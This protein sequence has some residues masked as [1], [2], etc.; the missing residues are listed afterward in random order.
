MMETF[1]KMVEHGFPFWVKGRD[2]HNKSIQTFER[3]CRSLG[4]LLPNIKK[5]AKVNGWVDKEDFW[6]VKGN[7]HILYHAIIH[8][9]RVESTLNVKMSAKVAK[10]SALASDDSDDS[11]DDQDFA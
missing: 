5:N 11:D 8:H 4:P 3:V 1:V 9:G 6:T 7:A 10:M 2:Y